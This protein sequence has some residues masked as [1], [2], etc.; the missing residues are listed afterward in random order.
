MDAG[1][2]AHGA[3]MRRGSHA[4]AASAGLRSKL[5]A[6]QRPRALERSEF[7]SDGSAATGAQRG[8][9]HGC[10]A[11]AASEQDASVKSRRMRAVHAHS[12][13]GTK[14]GATERI[15]REQEKNSAG[16]C[17][18][19]LEAEQETRTEQRRGRGKLLDVTDVA[20]AP[21]SADV[22]GE[23]ATVLLFAVFRDSTLPA[24]CFA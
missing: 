7:S 4:A 13:E 3:W 9:K 23:I 22:R 8:S 6:Q 19:S 12:S 17:G 1:E 24:T 18:F 10:A 11:H 2:T 15:R 14:G 20:D 16:G 21:R 5:A